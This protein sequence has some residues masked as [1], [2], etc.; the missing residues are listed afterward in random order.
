VIQ[1]ICLVDLLDTRFAGEDFGYQTF[2][3][4]TEAKADAWRF[5]TYASENTNTAIFTT[6]VE[7]QIELQNWLLMP[8]I[9]V[10]E[11]SEITIDVGFRVRNCDEEPTARA[12]CHKEIHLYAY[13][14]SANTTLPLT[15][16]HN[17]SGW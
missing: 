4:P 6:C 2:I 12:S 10:I 1:F 7:D 5:E 16:W 8:K 3:E 14:L 17:A 13:P 9:E 11:G 15:N